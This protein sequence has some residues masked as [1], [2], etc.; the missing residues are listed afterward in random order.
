[1]SL[2]T[3]RLRTNLY[4]NKK[5]DQTK[6]NVKGNASPLTIHAGRISVGQYGI[7]SSS[8]LNGWSVW[9][10]DQKQW[11][12][13]M[14]DNNSPTCGLVGIVMAALQSMEVV[15]ETEIPEWKDTLFN[16]QVV[17]E[18]P[19]TTEENLTEIYDLLEESPHYLEGDVDL[20]IGIAKDGSL[21][22]KAVMNQ[23]EVH[24]GKLSFVESNRLG[25]NRA[26]A[27]FA[28]TEEVDLEETK[29]RFKS[30]LKTQ[31]QKNLERRE[32]YSAKAKTAT[33]TTSAGVDETSDSS[34]PPAF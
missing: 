14:A 19:S 13:V 34:L 18:F 5:Y 1:M 17:V 11:S 12:S 2:Q 27:Q 7:F 23:P 29:G 32:R 4:V 9:M 31:R 8:Q 3:I 15:D 21:S 24:K 25:I 10:P 33:Q 6:A 30:A 20:S 16:T 26:F 22:I 28:A